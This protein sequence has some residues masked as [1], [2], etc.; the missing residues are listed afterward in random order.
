MRRWMLAAIAATA[1][2]AVP[3]A[4]TS[5]L[6]IETTR[7]RYVDGTETAVFEVS[8]PGCDAG[9][10]EVV[11]DSCSAG[12]V[13]GSVRSAL[14]GFDVRHDVEI[15]DG[16]APMVA[17]SQRIA[18]QSSYVT[19][20]LHR[21][22]D[23][24]VRLAA[25]NTGGVEAEP[26][27][28]SET[29]SGEV[30]ERAVEWVIADAEPG[31][32]RFSVRLQLVDHDDEPFGT[33]LPEVTVELVDRAAVAA[34]G[35][36][37]TLP[38]DGPLRSRLRMREHVAPAAGTAAATVERPWVSAPA[39]LP[40]G[41][42]ATEARL[43]AIGGYDSDASG[44]VSAHRV[45]PVAD[46][47]APHDDAPVSCWGVSSLV[48]GDRKVEAV[49]DIP[50]TADVS[51]SAWSVG[52]TTLDDAAPTGLVDRDSVQAAFVGNFTQ[53]GEP[54]DREPRDDRG[55]LTL[56]ADP[57]WVRAWATTLSSASPVTDA[58]FSS[59]LLASSQT[60]VVVRDGDLDTRDGSTVDGTPI[61]YQPPDGHTVRW[62]LLWAVSS[63][64]ME[65]G[66]RIRH[67][68][69]ALIAPTDG[70]AA[71]TVTP[72]M[73]PGG[74][75]LESS[76]RDGIPVS[77]ALFEVTVVTSPS[78]D[79]V[80]LSTVVS[81]PPGGAQTL[82]VVNLSTGGHRRYTLDPGPQRLE[83]G[84]ETITISRTCQFTWTSETP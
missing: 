14:L 15:T 21:A 10:G 24:R 77:A 34:R 37:A 48:V 83:L 64:P 38:V 69:G 36:A 35:L 78:D 28:G 84:D 4:G 25:P 44:H 50:A 82:H 11:V 31:S 40:Y 71:V 76:V 2:A 18:D 49:A 29:P 19:V 52:V 56:A 6:S 5:S 79:D 23:L 20:D 22:G 72:V 3:D 80:P 27:R 54:L 61:V 30:T 32:Y 42:W 74:Y 46:V 75:W 63:G 68:D 81:V 53:I 9:S 60:H 13:T 47:A 1:I 55:T 70:T 59:A 57:T 65:L 12:R 33:Y 73:E 26:V 7:H 51:D 8:A 16:D 45:L 17:T 39:A 62:V 43:D 67:G 58:A 66:A 41:A